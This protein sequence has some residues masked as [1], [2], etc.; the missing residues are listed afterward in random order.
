MIVDGFDDEFMMF[1]GID[2]QFV[3]RHRLIEF[4]MDCKG[5]DIDLRED[6]VEMHEGARFWNIERENRFDVAWVFE[7]QVLR[8]PF[9]CR[10]MRSFRNA[11]RNYR[12]RENDNVAAFERVAFVAVEIRRAL[13]AV[14]GMVFEDEFAVYRFARPCRR[15]HFTDRNAVEN[16]CERIARE[17]QIRHRI[18]NEWI[19]ADVVRQRALDESGN[20]ALANAPHRAFD[21]RL[22]RWNRHQIVCQ[23]LSERFARDLRFM[24]ELGNELGFDR[25]IGIERLCD[26]IGEIQHFDAGVAQPS[27][28]IRA[29]GC[30][31]T[32]IGRAISASN[33]QV[34]VQGDATARFSN[35][36]FLILH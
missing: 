20:F 7:K 24:N 16:D 15:E 21:H 25:G 23:D 35:G 19:I 31:R 3:H 13:T 5:S 27:R 2:G 14:F 1:F 8:E 18:G 10:G 11:D 28:P 6:G 34:R 4:L 22:R 36:Q 12:R 30:R 33:F 32:T 9:D 17:I 26:Q 29:K